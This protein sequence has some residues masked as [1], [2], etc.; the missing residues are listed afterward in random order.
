M[1][2]FVHLTRESRWAEVPDIPIYILALG[3]SF[4]DFEYLCVGDLP[5]VP[6][7]G[8]LTDSLFFG[9]WKKNYLCKVERIFLKSNKNPRG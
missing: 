7:G 3:L 9:F 2:N 1:I 4:L 5:I 8:V 6:A